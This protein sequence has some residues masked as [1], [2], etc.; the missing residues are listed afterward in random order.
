MQHILIESVREYTFL[1]DPSDAGYHDNKKKDNAW[2]HISEKFEGWP[3]K[4]SSK[5]KFKHAVNKEI[6]H[7][8]QRLQPSVYVSENMRFLETKVQPPSH[9]EGTKTIA[10]ENNKDSSYTLP[11]VLEGFKMIKG[12]DESKDVA[13]KWKTTT[14][15]SSKALIISQT[16]N[17]L[18]LLAVVNGEENT[19]ENIHQLIS[20]IKQF[21][22]AKS[23]LMKEGVIRLLLRIR[24]RTKDS[25]VNSFI[26]EAFALLGYSKPLPGQGIRILTIDGGGTRGLL[27]IK[28][29]KKLEELS[30]KRIHEMFDFVC[31]VSTGAII[32]C[33]VGALRRDLESLTALY[34]DISTKIFS[35]SP[36]WGTGNLVWSHSYYDTPLWEKHLKESFG[37]D[38]L[39]QSARDPKALKVAIISAIVNQ[40]PIAPY[41]FRNYSLPWKVQSQYMGS[42]NHKIWEAIRAS[43][44]APT[45][46]EE[47]K[48]GSL[49][50]QDGGI[51]VNNP[52][53]VAI[54]EA[55]Q[56]WPNC[57]IQ[58]VVSF[59]T[60]RSV[61][62]GL[63]INNTQ[64]T[65]SSSWKTKFLKIL[66]SATDTEAVHT[67]LNDLLPPSVYYRFNP[68]LTEMITLSEI[69]SKK[70]EQLERDAL[71]AG[72]VNNNAIV[73][74]QSM[75]F[76]N[77]S[78]LDNNI[79][80][81]GTVREL[82]MVVDLVLRNEV[83]CTITTSKISPNSNRIC[84][85]AGTDRQAIPAL[86]CVGLMHCLLWNSRKG[87]AKEIEKE[88]LSNGRHVTAQIHKQYECKA[89]RQVCKQFKQM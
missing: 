75:R 20:H 12:T 5:R 77:D 57:P 7:L 80:G 45:Y 86:C 6:T 18:T 66:D 53:A 78:Q 8:L 11:K 59:G 69:D 32:A 68:Y 33:S 34:R 49:L 19:L 60:G 1:Y 38:D 84:H 36:L 15:V 4:F 82:V 14:S 65:N 27:V 29:L 25:E 21:P 76:S 17:V 9:P 64:T 30:G 87:G 58:C 79:I 46:F 83:I 40:N 81:C 54:H 71:M 35:Q 24:Q 10:S 42:H 39:I 3:A 31:G 22:E 56:I 55:K 85:L 63:E 26:N 23:Q 67:M 72:E 88:T 13:P 2:I 52:T 51:L 16:N 47:C 43:A 50:H 48:L 44:A 62:G 41:V 61:P 28:M 73:G 74:I 89:A 37:Q 70:L